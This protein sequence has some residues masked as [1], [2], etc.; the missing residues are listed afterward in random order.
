MGILDDLGIDAIG[1]VSISQDKWHWI[2]LAMIEDRRA[3]VTNA[4]KRAATEEQREALLDELKRLSDLETYVHACQS[5]DLPTPPEQNR[6]LMRAV[7][8]GESWEELLAMK[9]RADSG[10]QGEPVYVATDG[11]IPW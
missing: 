7:L 5:N 6:E 10:Q 3:Q 8:Q 9:D 2:A 4:N 1:E 11:D